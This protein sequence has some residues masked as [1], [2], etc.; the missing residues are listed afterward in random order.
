MFNSSNG[1]VAMAEGDEI[2]KAVSIFIGGGIGR[3]E[4]FGRMAGIIDIVLSSTS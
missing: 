2:S 3:R 4:V 1:A